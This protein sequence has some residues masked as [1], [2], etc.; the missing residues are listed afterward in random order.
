MTIKLACYNKHR[1]QWIYKNNRK[2]QAIDNNPYIKV[3]GYVF[4]CLSVCTE[5]SQ[6]RW[7]DMVFLY[8][9]D[10]HRSCKGL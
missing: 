1:K 2:K 5:G 6:K 3:T 7:T 10:C 8:N 4:V 9:V